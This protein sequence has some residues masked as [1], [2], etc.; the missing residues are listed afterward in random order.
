MSNLPQAFTPRD[1][2]SALVIADHLAKSGMVPKDYIGKPGAVFA[3]MEMGAHLGLS[4]MQ[5]CQSIAVINGRPALWGDGALGVVQAHPSFAGIDEDGPT[6]A[7]AAKRGRCKISRLVHG[8][9]N[10]CERT[11]SLDEAK[12]AGLAGKQGP[13]TQYPGRMLQMRARSLAMRDLFSD[14]LKGL[15]IAEEVIDVPATVTVV[16]DMM[17]R[18]TD[19]AKESASNAYAAAAAAVVDPD[20][21]PSTVALN[22]GE[23]VVRILGVNVSS[24]TNAKTQKPWTKYAVSASLDGGDPDDLGTFSATDGGIAQSLV[25]KEA[26]VLVESA[27]VNGKTYLN[28]KSIRPA[29]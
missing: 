26:I 25:G 11:F 28:L 5:A 8:A 1:A 6:Q 19:A 14:A 7:L 2:A 9:I 3:A 17:P 24:G 12:T 22:P 13:W 4:A 23:N 15:G 27:D 29:S 21:S 20:P 10:V 16:E 18:A